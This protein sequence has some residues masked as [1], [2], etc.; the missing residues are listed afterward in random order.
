VTKLS[1][2]DVIVPRYTLLYFDDDGETQETDF[3]GDAITY[4]GQALEFGY[5]S[6]EGSDT[7]YLYCF[8]LNDIFGDCQYSDFVS[9]D[10]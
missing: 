2:G 10:M 6:L 4:D 5:E 1:A 9:F 8:C 7:S 3:E